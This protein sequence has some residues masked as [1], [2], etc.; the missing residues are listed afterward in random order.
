MHALVGAPVGAPVAEPAGPDPA[1]FDPAAFRLPPELEASAPPEAWGRRRDAVRLLVARGGYPDGPRLEHHRFT[2]L[3]GLLAAGDVLAVNISATLPASVDAE[4][5]DGVPATL[6]FA[7]RLPGGLWMVEVRHRPGAPADAGRASRPWLDAAPGLVVRLPGGGRVELR[8]PASAALGPGQPVRLWIAT[9]E[10]PQP[11][12][13][14]LARYGRPIR[15]AYVARPWPI[16]SYQTVFAEVP[17]SAEMPS[18]A[19]P[20]SAEVITRLVS[21]GVGIAPFVLHCGVSSPEQ[22]EPP[23]AEWYQVPPTS[24]AQINAARQAGR[25]VIAV[26]TTAVRALETVTDPAGVVHPGEGWTELVVTRDR[27]VRSVDGLLTG[28]HEPGASH[29]A[30][31]EAI[32]GPELVA[33]SYTAALAA[34]YLWHEFGDSLLVRP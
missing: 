6:H 20:F 17:G 10:L 19:R 26:G 13:A 24:A 14:Y 28:W 8:L 12:L 31:L 23:A 11:L 27:A 7:G 4:T 30:M 32:A 3:P 1:G 15:Y 22:H 9:V 25:R 29:L 21:R 2:D 5:S 34:G 33:A 18:A 16:A